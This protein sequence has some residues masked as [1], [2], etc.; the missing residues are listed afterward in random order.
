MKIFMWYCLNTTVRKLNNSNIGTV[1]A[2]QRKIF[3]LHEMGEQTKSSLLIK[4]LLH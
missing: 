1:N 3:Y 2:V 4:M